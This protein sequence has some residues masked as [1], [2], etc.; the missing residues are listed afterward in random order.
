MSAV[1]WFQCIFRQRAP[2]L[3]KIGEDSVFTTI[4]GPWSMPSGDVILGT[5]VALHLFER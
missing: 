1:P 5:M 2:C 3:C 4:G